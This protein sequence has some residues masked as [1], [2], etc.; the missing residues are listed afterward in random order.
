[1]RDDQNG[2]TARHRFQIGLDD[3]LAFGIKRRGG[4][5]KNENARL[6]DERPC[7]GDPLALSARQVMMVPRFD[8]HLC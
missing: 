4:F 7:N 3:L 1:M 8:G 6:G 5:I 2:A